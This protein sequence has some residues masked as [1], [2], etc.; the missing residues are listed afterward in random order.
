MSSVS[1]FVGHLKNGLARPNR[2]IVDIISPIGGDET[3]QIFCHTCQLPMRGLMTFEHK[4]HVGPPYK[5]PYSSSYEPVTFTFY[6]DS[7][8]NTRRYFDEWQQEVNNSWSNTNNYM[9]NFKGEIK[10]TTLNQEGNE[11]YSVKLHDAYPLNIG[12]VDLS[13]SQNNALTNVSVTI[14]YRIWEA[15][16]NGGYDSNISSKMFGSSK[17]QTILN[18]LDLA[19]RF[20]QDPSIQNGLDLVGGLTKNPKVRIGVDIASNF[21]K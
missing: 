21:F 5:A 13:Y 4:T 6:A 11:R 10:I 15:S 17:V 14:S 19:G 8:M 3:V 12:A 7:N 2:Y 1:E 20:I 16:T 9:N 18:G